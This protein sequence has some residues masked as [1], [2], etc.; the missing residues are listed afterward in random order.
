M[1]TIRNEQMR[2]M[3]DARRRAFVPRLLEHARA[4]HAE[5]TAALGEAGLAEH[6][7]A[8]L[9]LADRYE[10]VG[11]QDLCRLLDLSLVFGLGW[12]S[13][14]DLRW[15]HVR[16]QDPTLPDPGRRLA[17]LFR[18]ALQRLDSEGT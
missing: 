16:M 10:V 6:V 2:A 1:L 7:R 15:M 9:R 18:E 13:S 11:G 14:E 3:E 4:C 5:R 12:D 17:I 8:M